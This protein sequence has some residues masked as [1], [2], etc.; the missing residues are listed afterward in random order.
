[1][2]GCITF[3]L[4]PSATNQTK[5]PPIHLT[6]PHPIPD[7]IAHFPYLHLFVLV[8]LWRR[9]AI[10]HPEAPAITI[11]IHPEISQPPSHWAQHIERDVAASIKMSVPQ[12]PLTRVRLVSTSLLDLPADGFTLH[13]LHRE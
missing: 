7:R 3:V 13:L 9:V 2:D 12:C 10:P 5:P 4:S 8:L 6:D 1:M 11:L